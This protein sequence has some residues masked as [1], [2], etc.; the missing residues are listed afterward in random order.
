MSG[1]LCDL[2]W[3]DP[4][5]EGAKQTESFTKNKNSEVSYFFND[6]PLKKVL[7]ST[8]T[9]L[10]VRAHEVQMDGYKFHAYDEA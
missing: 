2:L 1:L 3:S 4:A 10:L 5:E 8:K 6:V 9:R 7:E